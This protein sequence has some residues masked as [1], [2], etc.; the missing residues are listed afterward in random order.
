MMAVFVDDYSGTVIVFPI[1][2]KSEIIEKV[3]EVIAYAKLHGHVIKRLRS[4]NT[5]EFLLVEMKKVYQKNRIYHEH[6]TTYCPQQNGCVERQN[7]TIIEMA[8]SMLAAAFSVIGSCM[9]SRHIFGIEC[10]IFGIEYR[11]SI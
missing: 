6:S 4:D 1:Q 9:H 5:K 3:E 10:R 8:R 11:S 7:R 2:H